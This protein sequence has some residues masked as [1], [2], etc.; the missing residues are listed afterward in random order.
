MWLPC[1]SIT[2]SIFVKFFYWSIVRAPCRNSRLFWN[3]LVISQYIFEINTLP[4]QRVLTF[5]YFQWTIKLE[6]RVI[7]DV[8]DTYIQQGCGLLYYPLRLNS[9]CIF[10]NHHHLLET[11]RW[12]RVSDTLQTDLLV[13]TSSH[14]LKCTALSVIKGLWARIQRF[15]TSFERLNV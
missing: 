15:T 3:R 1:A 8:L 2:G 4:N 10:L 13:R 9:S 6:G 14:E 5:V 7:P 12:L 11:G